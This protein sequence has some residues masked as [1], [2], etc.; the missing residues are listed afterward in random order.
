MA[1]HTI[2]ITIPTEAINKLKAL[3]IP[4]KNY[5]Q[6]Y[7]NFVDDQL[8]N[9]THFAGEA[10]E[11]WVEEDDNICDYREGEPEDEE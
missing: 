5:A 7:T 6:V 11:N 1:T 9:N 4:E 3:G 2:T 8:G 10:F